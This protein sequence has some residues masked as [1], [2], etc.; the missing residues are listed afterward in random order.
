MVGCDHLVHPISF[1]EHKSSRLRILVDSV[2]SADFEEP[3]L[4]CILII[5]AD[6]TL[7]ILDCILIIQADSTLADCNDERNGV[8]WSS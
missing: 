5:Q 1:F 4:D 7:A 6:S 3:I 2:S 8:N